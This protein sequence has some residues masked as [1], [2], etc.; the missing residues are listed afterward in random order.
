[1]KRN[2][3]RLSQK[4]Q[5]NS[6]IEFI[7]AIQIM[8][9][10]A[11][12]WSSMIAAES[13]INFGRRTAQKFPEIIA[14]NNVGNVSKHLKKIDKIISRNKSGSS[15]GRLCNRQKLFVDIVLGTRSLTVLT[16]Q[17]IPQ[18]FVQTTRIFKGIEWIWIFLKLEAL[19]KL[20]FHSKRKLNF[21]DPRPSGIDIIRYRR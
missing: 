20:L 14:R 19:E 15:F 5:S 13:W 11:G 6:R 9:S 17:M 2:K 18:K 3:Q 16:V 10:C 21:I 8:S 7:V 1:M 12:N 4:K